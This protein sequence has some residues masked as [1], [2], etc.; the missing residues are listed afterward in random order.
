MQHQSDVRHS[1][2]D[3][4][5][6]R[7]KG[8]SY[9][10]VAILIGFFALGI[11]L[12]MLLSPR[13]TTPPVSTEAL[14]DDFKIA[15]QNDPKL[16]LDFLHQHAEQVF[17][18][19]LA[20]QE[21]KRAKAVEAQ[22]HQQ[23][24]DPLKP[25]IDEAR[26]M[27]GAADAPVTIVEY[28]DFLCPF[29]SKAAATLNAIMKQYEGKVRLFFKHMPLSSHKN[30]KLAAH[31]F[32]AA[33]LQNPK[34]AWALYDAMFF[35]QK[36]LADLGEPWLLETAR[37]L[38]LDPQRLEA[39]AASPAVIERVEQDR[40]EADTLGIPGTP[41]FLVNGVLIS[42]AVPPEDWHRTLSMVFQHLEKT[43]AQR[44]TEAQA[45][46]TTPVP[47]VAPAKTDDQAQPPARK[48]GTE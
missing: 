27:L 41:S 15:I 19:V 45:T 42:G 10:R 6:A 22:Q 14:L 11:G 33:A 43:A 40:R 23:L 16:V 7:P 12:G 47:A 29:C 1:K 3:A 48:S 9:G 32:E 13:K 4:S 26:P 25:S 35:G 31:Y 46:T 20:G 28:S 39:D 44:T 21:V 37:A 17:E 34:L 18:I 2:S 24:L 38:G 8:L 5:S 36:Q 30:A